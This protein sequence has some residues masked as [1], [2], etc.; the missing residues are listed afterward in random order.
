MTKPTKVSW[1]MEDK[2]IPNHHYIELKHDFSDLYEKYQ[3][4]E[5]NQDI[6]K[7]IIKNA[8]EYMKMFSNEK[9]EEILEKN[10]LDEYFKRIKNVN[11]KFN[12]SFIKNLNI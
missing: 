11:N 12:Y 9:Y 1:L 6:C 5:K 2:L 4:C 3:W 10:V 7:K 8:N